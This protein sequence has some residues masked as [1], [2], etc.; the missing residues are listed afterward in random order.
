M[1]KIK[2][3]L[4]VGVAVI[5][6]AVMLVTGWLDYRNSKRLAAEGKAVSAE[7]LAKDIE[8]GRRGRKSYFLEVQFKTDSGMASKRVRVSSSRFDAA[9]SGGTVPAHYLP[10]D[11]SVCQIGETVETEWTGILVGLG[12]WVVGAFVSFS[13]E[14]GQGGDGESSA[15]A[16]GTDQQQAA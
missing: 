5:L 16:D 9:R 8:R 10:S 13:K 15:K 6:G 11:P 7:V 2:K 14:K 4:I 1:S 3:M 12:A